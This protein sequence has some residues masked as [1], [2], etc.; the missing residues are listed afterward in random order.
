MVTMVKS[1]NPGTPPPAKGP[2]APF[3]RFRRRRT[4]PLRIE[5]ASF[6]DLISMV[7]EGEPFSLPA[8]VFPFS[9]APRRTDGGTRT[10]PPPAAN[11]RR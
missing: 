11:P 7:K 2:G 10:L 6:E 5:L 9:H 8:S 3:S 1:S 4:Q